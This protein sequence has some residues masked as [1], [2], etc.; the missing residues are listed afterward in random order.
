MIKINVINQFITVFSN[1]YNF[2]SFWST[3]LN[4]GYRDIIA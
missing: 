1:I 2:F 4:I 3:W